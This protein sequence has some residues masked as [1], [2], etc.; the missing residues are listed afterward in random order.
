MR[1]LTRSGSLPLNAI[2]LDV[3]WA[4]DFVIDAVANTLV[5]NGV[6]ATWM[7]TRDSPAIRRLTRHDELFKRGIHPNH[8]P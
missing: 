4:P 6:K 2:T 8:H 5:S 7:V 1:V 3:E